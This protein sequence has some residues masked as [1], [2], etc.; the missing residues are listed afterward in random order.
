MD[1]NRP[2]HETVGKRTSGEI[3]EVM[4][5]D[6]YCG[7]YFPAKDSVRLDIDKQQ[8]YFCSNKCKQAYLAS[9][10]QN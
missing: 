9:R 3:D 1:Q 10:K 5:K 4:L 7:V 6:P 8:F 2:R